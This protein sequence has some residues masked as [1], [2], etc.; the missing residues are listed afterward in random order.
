MKS[1]KTLFQNIKKKK[2]ISK[3]KSK[4]SKNT[5]T[6]DADLSFIKLNKIFRFLSDEL[7]SV[8]FIEKKYIRLSI[9]SSVSS[10]TQSSSFFF[11]VLIEIFH[12]KTFSIFFKNKT[13]KKRI[14]KL[15]FLNSKLNNDFFQSAFFEK[16]DEMIVSKFV[17]FQKDYHISILK[18]IIHKNMLHDHEKTKK[19]ISSNES[20][21]SKF[22]LKNVVHE[23][24]KR[25]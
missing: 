1:V 24:S 23:K 18:T 19:N 12:D 5:I 10:K 15:M 21:R 25:A 4:K 13:I 11:R 20:R 6:N 9:F 22:E 8:I 14:D 7:K 2:N 3:K 16:F 17:L